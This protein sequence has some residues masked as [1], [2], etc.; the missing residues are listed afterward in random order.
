MVKSH[1]L[2]EITLL[3]RTQ[4]IQRTKSWKTNPNKTV[5]GPCLWDEWQWVSLSQTAPSG[6]P[7]DLPVLL[8]HTKHWSSAW[9]TSY[10]PWS[11]GLEI[12]DIIEKLES[13]ESSVIGDSSK[14]STDGFCQGELRCLEAPQ[15]ATGQ[16]PCLQG[17]GE[18]LISREQHLPPRRRRLNWTW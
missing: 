15:G 6:T 18:A 8:I 11:R 14:D 4:W 3:R 5:W 10:F 2:Q 9:W 16:N 12:E 1:I 7:G 13:K 17:A